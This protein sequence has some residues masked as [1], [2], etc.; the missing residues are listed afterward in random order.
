MSGEGKSFITLNMGMA[1]AIAGKKT[2]VI[3]LDLRKPKLI[4]YLQPETPEK[5]LTQYL[6]GQTNIDELIQKYKGQDNLYYI[7]CGPLP[8]NPAELLTNDR[9]AELVNDL[10]KQFDYIL[11]DTPPVGLVTDAFLLAPLVDSTLF[12]VRYKVT[13]KFQVKLLEEYYQQINLNT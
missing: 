10:R 5:G 12:V 1:F 2:I 8:P 7:N 4:R 9:I 3:E 13:S 6:V 11:I